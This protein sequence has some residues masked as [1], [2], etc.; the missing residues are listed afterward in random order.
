MI[1]L[2]AGAKSFAGTAIASPSAINHFGRRDPTDSCC[3]PPKSGT[4]QVRYGQHVPTPI[5]VRDKDV[6][7]V[8]AGLSSAFGMPNTP[9][10]ISALIR[11]AST[12]AGAV[13]KRPEVDL[14]NK[15]R[16]AFEFFYPDAKDRHNGYQPDVVDFFSTLK[17]F[18]EVGSGWAGTG[19]DDSP[20]LYRALKRAITHLMI[21]RGREIDDA[22][23]RTHPYMTRMVRPGNIIVT[24]NWDTLIERFAELNAIPL[25]LTSRSQKFGSDEVVL[26]KLHGSIDW[27]QSSGRQP[28]YKD[29]DYAHLTQLRF[30]VRQYRMKIPTDPRALL[31]IETS[32]NNS[33][34]AVKSRSKEPWIVTMATGKADDLGPLQPIWRDA[35]RAF[36]HARTLEA[37]GYS[38]PPDDVEVRTVIRAGIQRGSGIKKVI[39]RNPAP[40]VHQ[41]FRALITRDIDSD[42]AA[43]SPV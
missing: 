20:E 15:L 18:L 6:F 34:Q 9:A 8:G 41:R 1:A 43:V 5:P 14:V 23:L 10:L 36:S 37:V 38:M 25:R 26:L 16:T 42:Y 24:T 13:W 30:A 11:F 21:V 35:Y 27:C 29:S 31:R 19:L 2:I 40:D 39:V 3:L 22:V 4:A 7:I 12:P 32:V 28:Q 33:W 17:T